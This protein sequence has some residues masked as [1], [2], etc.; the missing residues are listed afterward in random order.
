LAEIV[1]VVGVA[2]GIS[3]TSLVPAPFGIVYIAVTKTLYMLPAGSIG[4][5]L[6]MVK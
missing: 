1:I 6:E 4:V 3:N 2:A 5:T